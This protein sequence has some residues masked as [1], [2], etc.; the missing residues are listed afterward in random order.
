LEQARAAT[1][2][3]RAGGDGADSA[4]GDIDDDQARLD[5]YNAWLAQVAERDR[6]Q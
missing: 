4:D 1:L 3:D 5:A 2:S 6:A